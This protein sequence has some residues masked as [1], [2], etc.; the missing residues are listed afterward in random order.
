MQSSPSLDTLIEAF[1]FWKGEPV[2][3]HD[4]SKAL[5]HTAA[6]IEQALQEMIRYASSEK[7]TRGIVI[8][9]YDGVYTLGTHPDASEHIARLTKEELQK[10]LGKSSLETLAIILYQGPVRRSDIDYVRGVNS[11]FILRNLLLR[12]LIDRNPDPKDERTFTYSPSLEL[13]A[14]LGVTR[15]QDLPDFEQVIQSLN[16]FNTEHIEA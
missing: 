8:V 14:H 16:T 2:S 10:E 4:I 12:G 9:G 5:G 13:L 6:D 7:N 11:Q 1:L 3:V 15:V